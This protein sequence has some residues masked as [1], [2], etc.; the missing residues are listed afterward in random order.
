M[1]PLSGIENEMATALQL[2]VERGELTLDYQPKLTLATGLIA[3]VEAL[4]RWEDGRFGSVP[5]AQFIPLAERSGII[6]ALTESVVRNVLRQ[7]TVWRD[8]GKTLNIAVNIS[9]STLRDVDFPDFLQHLCMLEGVP[10]EQITVELTEGATQHV[11]RLLD[12]LT[13][14][15]LKG[16]GVALDDFGTG[17]SSLLQLRQLPFTELKIDQCFVADAATA[18]DSRQI[19]KS[20]IDLAHALGLV[21]VA[22]GVEDAETLRLLADLGCDH[23]QGY[24]VARPMKP[25][26]LVPWMLENKGRWDELRAAENRIAASA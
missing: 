2:A 11:V 26:D 3:G 12:T 13:R 17:Y 18:E 14:F 16:M 10:C 8:Q 6:D 25:G 19:V 22:E 9:A 7:W 21:A 23:V 20:V 4:A 5:P 1:I 24:H 15:R